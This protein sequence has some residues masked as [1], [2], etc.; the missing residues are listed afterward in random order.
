MLSLIATGIMVGLVLGT[1]KALEV[2]LVR[3]FGNSEV[4]L[5]NYFTEH[6]VEVFGLEFAALALLSLLTTYIAMRKHLRV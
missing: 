5:W 1:A 6:G 4:S 3:Y 2:P